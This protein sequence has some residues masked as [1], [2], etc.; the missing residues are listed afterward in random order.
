M[1]RMYRKSE[2]SPDEK[3]RLQAIRDHFHRARPSVDA[4]VASGEY[5][6][7]IK[8]GVTLEAMQIAFLLKQAREEADLSLAE[9]AR[10]C[11]LDRSAISRLEN[12]VYE[13]TTINT[14]SRLADAYGKRFVLQL[15]DEEC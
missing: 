6:E 1:K 5:A 11:G 3:A 14:L 2:H 8:H 10:R 4:L 15:V 13:N 9:V 12:G 7:P